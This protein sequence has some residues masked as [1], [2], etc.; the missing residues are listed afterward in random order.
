M[1]FWQP[2]TTWSFEH[3]SE[4]Q[5][6]AEAAARPHHSTG[7]ALSAFM[8]WILLSVLVFAWGLPPVKEFLNGGPSGAAPISSMG[9]RSFN[10]RSPFCTR[11]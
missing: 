4:E 10:I 9:F 1:K 11:R 6:A 7:G 2:R 3:E 8:P 5:R